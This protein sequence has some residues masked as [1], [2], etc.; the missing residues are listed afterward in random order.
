MEHAW[1]SVKIGDRNM[2]LSEFSQEYY[3]VVCEGT[4]ER[5]CLMIGELTDFNLLVFALNAQYF[6]RAYEN[7]HVSSIICTEECISDFDTQNS[8]KGI[9]VC[10]SPKYAYYSI[11]NWFIKN[12]LGYCGFSDNKTIV[13]DNTVIHNTAFIS[14]TDVEIGKN[15]VIEANVIIERGV[16]IG[17]GTI[18][19]AGAI[20]GM[21]NVLD[22][23]DDKGDLFHVDSAGRVVIGDNCVIGH[24][25]TVARGWMSGEYT[26][27]GN[28]VFLGSKVLIAHNVILGDNCDIKDNTQ[29]AGYTV[30]GEN[31]R[32][33]P[34]CVISNK[35]NIGKNVNVIIGSTVTD[36]LPDGSEVAGNFAIDKKKFLMWQFRKLSVEKKQSKL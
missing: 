6:K 17:N 16:K 11:H 24:Y 31:T 27:I 20:I 28:H 32:V 15:C 35:L 30:V 4:F 10:S 3:K 14:E 34:Q 1:R 9:A 26:E 21:D 36:N 19:R 25:V 33:A 7:E 29:I 13:G 22:T 5:P 12:N 8:Q 2:Q 23:R 18:V